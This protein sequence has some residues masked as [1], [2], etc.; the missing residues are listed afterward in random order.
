MNRDHNLGRTASGAD[1][2]AIAAMVAARRPN[3][4]AAGS[5]E[6]IAYSWTSELLRHAESDSTSDLARNARRI[7]PNARRRTAERQAAGTERVKTASA[8]P[9]VPGTK[10]EVPKT[11]YANLWQSNQLL[12]VSQEFADK[13]GELETS[14]NWS[15][16][17]KSSTAVGRYQILVSGLQDIGL[18][19]A[20]RNW[21]GYPHPDREEF[22]QTPEL[23][24]LAFAAYLKRKLDAVTH[25]ELESQKPD[26]VTLADLVGREIDGVGG[27]FKVTMAGLLAAAHREGE[28]RLKQYFDHLATNDWY[29]DPETFPTDKIPHTKRTIAEFF[30]Q[31]EERLRQFMTIPLYGNHYAPLL[32]NPENA[33]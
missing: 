16:E 13:I 12:G 10:P 26:E 3:P 6:H 33:T 5:P 25:T 21:L 11:P 31:V 9:P 15:A 23:Q 24:N 18:V 2:K 22:R 30:G 14:D 19:D 29:S 17:S 1:S 28:G 20:H 7:F 4:F 8:V 27:P 32:N